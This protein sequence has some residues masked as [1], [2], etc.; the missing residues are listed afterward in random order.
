MSE[1]RSVEHVLRVN[2]AGERGAIC[3]YKAQI[4]VSRLLYPSCVLPL[5]NMLAHEQAH[6]R[7]FDEILAE[8]SLRHCHA[9]MAWAIGGWLLGFFTALLGQRAIWVCTAAVESRVNAHLEHQVEFLGERDEQVLF[10]VQ[11]IRS[12]EASHEAHARA[13]GGTPTGLYA[14]L[15][16]GIYGAT[17]F[18]I[19][20]STNL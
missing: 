8:R 2:H 6:F 19:W 14:L 3:I 16:R 5:T 18:A 7:A 15:W 9:L 20:L 4:F 12:D 1:I 13:Q 11:S 17:S 10:A